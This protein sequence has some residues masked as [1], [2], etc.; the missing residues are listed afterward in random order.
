[1]ERNTAPIDQRINRMEKTF[2]H[3]KPSDVEMNASTGKRNVS[4]PLC[5]VMNAAEDPAKAIHMLR[6]LFSCTSGK[7]HANATIVMHAMSMCGRS[8]VANIGK[9]NP[10]MSRSTAPS[11]DA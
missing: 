11:G 10:L 5:S 8:A 2:F 3:A 9:R 4:A 1:R 6:V 7:E